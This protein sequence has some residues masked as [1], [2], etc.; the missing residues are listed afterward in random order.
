MKRVRIQRRDILEELDEDMHCK[1][2][3]TA[4]S[5]INV[6]ALPVEVTYGVLIRAVDEIKRL[7]ASLPLT[8]DA[9]SNETNR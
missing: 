2:P 3:G 4:N 7:R 1:R 9:E 6:F 5:D 8:Q